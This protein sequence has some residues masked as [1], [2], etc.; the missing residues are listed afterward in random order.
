MTTAGSGLPVRD[1][2]FG[3]AGSGLNDAG[4]ECS[5]LLH[6]F[7][8][9]FSEPDGCVF[10]FQ[11]LDWT[12]VNGGLVPRVLPKRIALSST[13]C[14]MNWGQIFNAG[15]QGKTGV[16]DRFRMIKSCFAWLG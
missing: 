8:F 6:Q 3:A 7:S 15:A 4:L 2:R 11:V 1:C 14:S 12:E 13:A 16:M 10:S 9:L 5:R